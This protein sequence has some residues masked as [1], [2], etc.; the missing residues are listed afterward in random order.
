GNT[1]TETTTMTDGA[2]YTT[3]GTVE[4]NVSG[5][6]VVTIT[7]LHKTGRGSYRLDLTHD[8]LKAAQNKA[9]VEATKNRAQTA[10]HY[11]H[12]KA[13]SLSGV[14]IWQDLNDPSHIWDT[15]GDKAWDIT[16]TAR[17]LSDKCL[18]HF[19]IAEPVPVGKVTVANAEGTFDVATGEIATGV[20]Q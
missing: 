20:F 12:K 3:I 10:L 7:E 11:A 1:F 5:K 19:R 4:K 16:I 8:Q 14:F 2:T 9:M 6:P 18:L 17:A 13:Q 15:N